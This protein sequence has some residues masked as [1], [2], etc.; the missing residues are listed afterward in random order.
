MENDINLT[1]EQRELAKE[2][3]IDCLAY[4]L[5][6]VKGVPATADYMWFTG[7]LATATTAKQIA[8]AFFKR[9]LGWIGAAYAAYEYSECIKSKRRGK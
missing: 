8:F 3:Y 6:G 4:G 9:S 2:D 1:P 7:K 5:I